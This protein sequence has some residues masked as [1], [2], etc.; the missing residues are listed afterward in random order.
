MALI[1]EMGLL[2]SDCI[3]RKKY[4]Y[5]FKCSGTQKMMIEFPTTGG[6]RPL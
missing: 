4:L 2:E 5:E 6:R 1:I 3:L